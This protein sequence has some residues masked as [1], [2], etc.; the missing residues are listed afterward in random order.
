MSDFDENQDAHHNMVSEQWWL[1]RPEHLLVWARLQVSES[2]IALVFDSAGDT[3]AY[4]SEDIARAALM[5]ADFRA[6]D[7]LDE[8]DADELGLWLEELE[9]PQG[10]GTEHEH[11]A[12]PKG[13]GLWRLRRHRLGFG[14]GISGNRRRNYPAGTA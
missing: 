13:I 14:S 2:G 8:A 12:R 11:L 4:E 7:G 5:D 9:P 3:L 6:F 1:A 10:Q